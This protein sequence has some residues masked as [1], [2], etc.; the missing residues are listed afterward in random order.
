M[1]TS[2]PVLAYI[3]EKIKPEVGE[4]DQKAYDE[5]VAYFEELKVKTTEPVDIHRYNLLN[6][7][8]LRRCYIS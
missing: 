4:E 2:I 6:P 8:R 5:L 7:Q 3:L 1:I